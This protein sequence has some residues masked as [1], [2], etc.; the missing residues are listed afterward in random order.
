MIGP[1]IRFRMLTTRIN[2]ENMLW[3][4]LLNCPL[5]EI[6]D[7]SHPKLLPSRTRKSVAAL[8]IDKPII[9]KIVCCF[10]LAKSLSGKPI[11]L[12]FI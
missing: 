12:K 7:I 11:S 8:A 5:W 2:W 10:L 4:P 3:N 9:V 1:I 6:L